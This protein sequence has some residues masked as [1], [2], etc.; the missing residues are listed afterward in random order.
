MYVITTSFNRVEIKG[1]SCSGRGGRQPSGNPRDRWEEE[2]EGSLLQDAD[3]HLLIEVYGGVKS[4]A[5][6]RYLFFW[7]RGGSL[8]NWYGFWSLV[9]KI[10]T[11]PCSYVIE[12]A[13]PKHEK[14]I[15]SSLLFILRGGR[16]QLYCSGDHVNLLLV[17][18]RQLLPPH[19]CRRSM[20]WTHWTGEC[21]NIP[22]LLIP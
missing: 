15:P 5:N 4:Q 7:R 13:I 10:F 9:G 2:E 21:I 6:W 17:H 22:F 3:G 12:Y 19:Y 20:D 8:A 14:R 1:R 16:L 18:C 11:V